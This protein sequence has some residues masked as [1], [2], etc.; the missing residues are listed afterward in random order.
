MTLHLKQYFPIFSDKT[1]GFL[2][3]NKCNV[4]FW[5]SDILVT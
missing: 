2:C 5:Y 4:I 3:I 1:G